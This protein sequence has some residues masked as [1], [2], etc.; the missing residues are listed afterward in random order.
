[1]GRRRGVAALFSNA[2]IHA[3]T[4]RTRDAE[5]TM[6][7]Q[8]LIALALAATTAG[9]AEPSG[10]SGDGD[11]VVTARP[12]DP[13][14]LAEEEQQLRRN[15]RQM[16]ELFERD[17]SQNEAAARGNTGG[18]YVNPSDAP[19]VGMLREQLARSMERL[20]NRCFGIEAKAQN[21]N[22]ILICGD[23]SGTADNQIIRS[24][25]DT[26]IVLP[27]PASEPAAPNDPAAPPQEP[28][29]PASA[30]P[31]LSPTPAPAGE[32]QS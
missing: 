18:I 12:V 6:K 11:I 24:S 15:L 29:A 3:R 32:G 22:V 26:T 16:R 23:N 17:K 30:A 1:V 31:P 2:G 21:G 10:G 14:R 13:A 20:E 7:L 8:I 19:S 25:E 27:P 9:A 4:A 28:S 5:T